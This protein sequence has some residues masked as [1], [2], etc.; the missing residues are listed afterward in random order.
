MVKVEKKK[1][2]VFRKFTYLGE[3]LAQLGDPSWEQQPKQPFR[4]WQRWLTIQHPFHRGS[5]SSAEVPAQG[6]GGGVAH[7]EAKGSEGAPMGCDYFAGDD[8]QHGGQWQPQ[9]LQPGGN[10]ARDN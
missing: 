9:L 3:D 10:Q 4:A 8:R 6:Q 7:Q 2:R 5:C 1:Q